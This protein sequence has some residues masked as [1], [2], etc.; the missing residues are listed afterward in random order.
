[1]WRG[2]PC[3]AITAVMLT[4]CAGGEVPAAGRSSS[5]VQRGVESAHR[6]EGC[7]APD[8]GPSSSV[9]P[10][11]GVV[12][13]SIRVQDLPTGCGAMTYTVRNAGYAPS[14]N[15]DEA[16][17]AQNG[18]WLVVEIE[19]VNQ[20]I[21]RQAVTADFAFTD[22]EGTFHQPVLMGGPEEFQQG[23]L[24]DGA[25]AAGLIYFDVKM[26]TLTNGKIQVLAGE[27]RQPYGHWSL[28]DQ[29]VSRTPGPES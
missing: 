29:A 1:M 10:I 26:S 24:S 22:N 18:T 27:P 12:G 6:P 8:D 13:D 4:G 11:N 7:A 21:A 19:A 20:G 5:D 23:P 17:A 2:L 28:G 14:M 3:L 16:H 25:Q 15:R 9:Q